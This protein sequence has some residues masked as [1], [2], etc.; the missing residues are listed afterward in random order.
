MRDIGDKIYPQL[1][2]ARNL[3]QTFTLNRQRFLYS[4]FPALFQ[5]FHEKI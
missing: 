4:S 3:F 1:I 5:S 2:A